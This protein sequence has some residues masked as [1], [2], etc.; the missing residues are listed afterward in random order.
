LKKDNNAEYEA[1]AYRLGQALDISVADATKQGEG[2]IG[3]RIFTSE[4][5]SM[6]HARDLLHLTDYSTDVGDD[7]HRAIYDYFASQGRYDIIRQLERLYIFNYLA[8]NLDF[9]YE[10]FGL[11]YD[12]NTFEILR[13]A[14][15]FDFNSAFAEYDDVVVYYEWIMAKLPDF[16]RN[17]PDIKT[18][19]QSEEFS[20]ALSESELSSEQKKCIRLR[21][22]YLCKI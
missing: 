21:A 8:I 20:N 2:V 3:C 11:L 16:M 7:Q 13:V 4:A 15:G 5:V 22:E 1:V 12:S 19:F 18:R 6:V 17:N 14:P 9:H 10:N